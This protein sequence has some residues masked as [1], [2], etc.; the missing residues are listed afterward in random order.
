MEK[1]YL[2]NKRVSED[3]LIASFHFDEK[4]Q[5]KDSEWIKPGE[6]LMIKNR[7]EPILAKP[8][9]VLKSSTSGFEVLIKI[10]G[11]FTNY[12]SN[13]VP[14]EL[15]FFRGPY[16]TPF[17]NKL[18]MTKKYITIGGGCGAAPIIFFND[19]YPDNI[20]KSIVGFKTEAVKKLINIEEGIFESDTGNTVIDELDQYLKN[21]T[22]NNEPPIVIACGS[23]GMC[24]ALHE[25]SRI[26]HYQLYVSLDERM[27]CGMGMCKGCPIKTKNGIKMVCKDGPIFD[28]DEIIW[29]W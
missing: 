9:S 21:R 22:K 18:N 19:C 15:F 20:E 3:F 12:L 17:E 13:S 23:A 14:G 5:E 1:I 2:Q 26:N 10:I 4:N 7:T 6:F 28:S 24:Q 29:E 25:H 27:G 11:R 16:G 8:F